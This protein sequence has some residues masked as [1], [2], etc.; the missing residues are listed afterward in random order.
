[1]QQL[2]DPKKIWN[3]DKNKP[4]IKNRIITSLLALVIFLSASLGLLYVWDKSQ[5]PQKYIVSKKDSDIQNK[6]KTSTKLVV[7][8]ESKRKEKYKEFYVPLPKDKLN[9]TKLSEPVRG[10]YVD[11]DSVLMGFNEEKIKTFE[12]YL[13]KLYDGKATRDKKYEDDNFNTLERC[14]A[15]AKVS[16]INTLVI[17]VKDDSGIVTF[18]SDIKIVNDIKS[19]SVENYSDTK[20]K[21]LINYL[22]KNNIYV[23]GRVVAFKD[24]KLPKAKPEHALALK[25]GG[26]YHDNEG[27]I[28]VN[29][30]DKYVWN[31]IVAIAKEAANNGFDEIH[32]DYVRFPDNAYR[33]DKIVDF[34][35]G[36]GKRKDDNIA[37]FLAFAKEELAPYGV[38]TSAAIFGTTAVS[39]EDK[40]ENIG[41][42]WRKIAGNVDRISPMMYPSHFSQG[43]FGYKVPDREPFGVIEQGMKLGIEKS[44]MANNPGEI[45]PWLQAFT[46]DWVN[47]FIE[48]TPE[49]ISKQM[50]GAQSLGINSYLMWNSKAKYN[51]LAYKYD[52][53][54]YKEDPTRDS[55]GRTVAQAIDLYFKSIEEKAYKKVYILT[56]NSIRNND[57]DAFVNEMEKEDVKF[58]K[59]IY[60]ENSLEGSVDLLLSYQ[61]HGK[62]IRN[63][64]VTIEVIKENGIYKIK[65]PKLT[66]KQE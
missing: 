33:Y 26:L 15:I 7:E 53:A 36:N 55:S 8:S 35:E 61:G 62:I 17:N 24:S 20:H 5:N 18:D 23:I 59:Y 16:E 1:M 30:F 4:L 51:P 52:H 43:W 19:D 6:G 9:P 39:W 13:K 48:Y 41:Q 63:Q 34:K 25:K 21:N 22:K 38:K 60:N 46:A 10:L 29:P 64:K 50:Q 57:Y 12:D 58:T 49:V 66:F 56:S 54:I 47:G 28:W 3:E 42:T 40:S 37:S 2:P 31:Y 32:F 45:T 11:T 44:S 14:I 27:R 65:M